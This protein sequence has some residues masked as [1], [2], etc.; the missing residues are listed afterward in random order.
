MQKEKSMRDYYHLIQNELTL[1]GSTSEDVQDSLNRLREML[2]QHP[3]QLAVLD[4]IIPKMKV[5]RNSSILS[6]DAISKIKIPSYLLGDGDLTLG[7][8]EEKIK[9]K[10]KNITIRVVG[11]KARCQ[12]YEKELSKWGFQ[13]G[14]SHS[15]PEIID[16]FEKGNI[17]YIV[18]L[19]SDGHDQ[20]DKGLK[21]DDVLKSIEK[22]SKGTRV[23]VVS[24]ENNTEA[25]KRIE[26]YKSVVRTVPQPPTV[27]QLEAALSIALLK[28]TR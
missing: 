21:V 23:V 2:K 28:T 18:I 10:Y 5:I 20:A 25:S 7:E 24:S 13:I 27:A 15:F 16:Y 6:A 9:E 22:H 14:F 12:F 1:S 8:L 3:D 11:D 4:E 19:A 26:G 17:P